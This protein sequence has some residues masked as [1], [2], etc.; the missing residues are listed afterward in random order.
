MFFHT[1][2][3]EKCFFILSFLKLFGSIKDILFENKQHF[4]INFIANDAYRPNGGLPTICIF[5]YF[6]F[7]SM[8]SKL[9]KSC[10]IISLF[11]GSIS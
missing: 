5:L 7:N 1:I 10:L 4:F 9:R 3:F 6:C 8:K 11:S 2:F